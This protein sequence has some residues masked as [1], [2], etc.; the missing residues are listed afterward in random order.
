MAISDGGGV[1]VGCKYRVHD[2]YGGSSGSDRG[3]AGDGERSLENDDKD[4][5]GIMAMEVVI[6]EK[7]EM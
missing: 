5:D 2:V 7:I 1:V 3:E 6:V 4:N